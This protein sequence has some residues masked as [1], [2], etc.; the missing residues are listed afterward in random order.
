M[1]TL[2]INSLP[3]VKDNWIDRDTIMLHA[4]FQILVD[5]VEK[6]DG[7]NSCDY[8]THKKSI[9]T[10]KKLYDWWNGQEDKWLI[11]PEEADKKLEKLIKVR[12]FL[13]T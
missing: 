9:N 11:K 1:R 6:E 7:L 10:C 4:C 13:W 2:K 8:K 5:F 12:T 3:P